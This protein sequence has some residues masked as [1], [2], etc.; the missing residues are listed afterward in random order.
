MKTICKLL[1]GLILITALSGCMRTLVQPVHQPSEHTETR[2]IQEPDDLGE[3]MRYYSSLQDKSRSELIE[4]YQYANS[5][6]RDSIDAHQRLKLLILL[7]LPDTGFQSTRAALDLMENP[8]EQIETTPATTAFKNLLVLL[9]KQQRA[10]NFKI[11][12]LSMK[13][14]TTEA[15]VK[16]LQDKI[17]AIKNIEKHFMRKSAF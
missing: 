3:L 2:I 5:H 17:N 16:T 13:L 4:E 6:Y 15:E 14:R 10:A 9:L 8:P 1:T 11:Q 12:N 7:L